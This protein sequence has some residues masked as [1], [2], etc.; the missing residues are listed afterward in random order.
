MNK[1]YH[2]KWSAIWRLTVKGK[3][4]SMWQHIKERAENKRGDCPTYK[5]VLL[6]MS[7]L[8]FYSWVL[9]E[10]E[11]WILVNSITDV[12]IDRIDNNGHYEISN[13][14]L[15]SKSDNARK[16]AKNKNLYAPLNQGWCGKCKTYLDFT[17][18]HKD[19]TTTNGV[20]RICKNCRK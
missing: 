13:L 2:R 10:L 11:K 12:S 8:E 9:P 19:R 15:L 4:V 16:Q 5:N 20:K 3:A 18:F 6:R 17:K 14:Q 1:E 7:R